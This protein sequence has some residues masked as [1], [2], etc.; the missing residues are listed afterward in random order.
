MLALGLVVG[1]LLLEDGSIGV[2]LFFEVANESL[3]LFILLVVVHGESDFGTWVVA[4]E[5]VPRLHY[6]VQSVLCLLG[7]KVDYIETSHAGLVLVQYHKYNSFWLR[8]TPNINYHQTLVSLQLFQQLVFLQQIKLP[9]YLGHI[10]EVGCKI[11]VHAF[12]LDCLEVSAF[13]LLLDSLLEPIL[14]L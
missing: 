1:N 11:V 6:H 10:L 9:E 2:E 7:S 5:Q 12:P 13:Y 8:G 14:L 3:L 4:E